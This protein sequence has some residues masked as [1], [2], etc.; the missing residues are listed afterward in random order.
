MNNLINQYLPTYKE[1]F[2]DDPRWITKESPHYI[3]HYFLDSVAN[4][5]ID[6]IEKTQEESFNKIV[7]LLRVEEPS[8]KIKYYFYPDKETK[9]ELMGDDGYAQ[10]VFKDFAIHILYTK[11]YK[12]IGEHEDT[13]LLSLQLGQAN[14]FFAEGLAEYLSWDRIV[15]N[16]KKEEWLREGNNKILP[17]EQIVSHQGWMNT[18]DDN[19][20][21]YYSFAGFF[22]KKIIEQF[23]ID[24][25]KSFYKEINRTMDYEYI[26]KIFTKYFDTS[27]SK[28]KKEIIWL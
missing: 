27:I 24:V 3:F 18:P 11:E 1:N 25:F 19:F 14:G 7:S 10:A 2:K 23:G 15:I 16:K 12:P 17:I 28:F 9:K 6:Q 13:H 21:Y 5:E 20:M 8:E 4:K 26:N 22:V